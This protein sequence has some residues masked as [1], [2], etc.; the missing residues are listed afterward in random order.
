MTH[1]FSFLGSSLVASAADQW[2]EM[3]DQLSVT[4]WREVTL[5]P[6]HVASGL[7][8]NIR[9]PKK[10]DDYAD[11]NPK[12][13]LI[14]Y[15]P[16]NFQASKKRSRPANLTAHADEPAGAH[17]DELGLMRQEVSL[18]R[19]QVDLL[20]RQTQAVQQYASMHA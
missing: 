3:H 9:S 18:L 1:T 11:V 12:V 10:G 17:V 15:A 8:G 14:I 19:L 20:Q 13:S 7:S 5:G 2:T 4:A 16:K 6:K